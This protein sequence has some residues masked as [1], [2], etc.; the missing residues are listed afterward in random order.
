[1]HKECRTAGS[2]ERVTILLF[3]LGLLAF[4]LAQGQTLPVY[5]LAPA[6]D[7]VDRPVTSRSSVVNIAKPVWRALLL[8]YHQIDVDY[9]DSNS[10]P[11]HLTA[12]MPAEEMQM[13]VRSFRQ[14]ASIAHDFSNG[15]AIIQYDVR[16]I[17]RPNGGVLSQ[18]IQF[19]VKLAR[20][21]HT[22]L[23]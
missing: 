3:L 1:M 2:Y 20:A 23:L 6:A 7:Q 8:V 17:T 11:R 5:A 18:D 19:A 14:A 13:A 21:Y 10:T 22:I 12:T 15:E 16:H 4:P 9:V